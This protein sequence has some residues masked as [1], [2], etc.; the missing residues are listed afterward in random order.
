MVTI[1]KSSRYFPQ[2]KRS[3]KIRIHPHKTHDFSIRQTTLQVLIICE[4]K[5]ENKSQQSFHHWP[6]PATG[7]WT[8]RAMERKLKGLRQKAE[9]ILREN[10]GKTSTEKESETIGFTGFGSSQAL[11]WERGGKCGV[12]EVMKWLHSNIS[13]IIQVGDSMW[14]MEGQGLFN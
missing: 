12:P 10:T 9:D 13:E 7:L 5:K 6:T 3:R 14:G 2:T 1:F 11:L 8:Q 4:L